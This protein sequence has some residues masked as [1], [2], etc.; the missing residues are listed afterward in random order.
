MTMRSPFPRSAT[1]VAALALVLGACGSGPDQAVSTGTASTRTAS[2]GTASTGTSGQ[3]FPTI[4]VTDVATGET[5][6]LAEELAGGE[7]P[8]LLWFWA[9]H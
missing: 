3:S 8:V 9:P 5:I 1:G 6:D 7:L 4:D 2:T